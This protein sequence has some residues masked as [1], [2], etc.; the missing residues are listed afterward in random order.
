MSIN[1][2]DEDE[3][4]ASS[5]ESSDDESSKKKRS[6]SRSPKGRAE[7]SAKKAREKVASK[8]KGLCPGSDAHKAQRWKEYKGDWEY[9]R[10][11]N[12][13]YSNMQKAKKANAA[14]KAYQEKLGWGKTE[15]TVRLDEETVRRLDIADV[16][17]DPKRGI[18]H[19]TGYISASE[20][21]LWEVERDA[22]L[23]KAGWKITW[24]FEGVASGPLI[25]ALF[26]AGINVEFKK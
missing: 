4:S 24:Y 7:S 25:G 20:A 21:I 14:V 16:D 10:W 12:V 13:Y 15:V 17:S 23:V 18:E 22:M 5:S 3:E 9:K 6:R 26:D 11:E 19:K 8:A 2:E 1:Y